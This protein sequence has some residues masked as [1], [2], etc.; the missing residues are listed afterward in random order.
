[1]NLP[2]VLAV[3]RGLIVDTFAQARSAGITI[4]LL[5]VTAVCAFFCFS[6]D[7]VGVTPQLPTAPWEAKELIPQSEV[8]RLKLSVEQTRGEGVDV[9]TGEIRLLF[10]AVHIPLQRAPEQSVR[11]VQVFLAGIIAD[12]IGVLLALVWTA[13][14][15]PGF[16]AAANAN[17]LF[18]K[19][20]SRWSLLAG[21][22]LAILLLV[23]AQATLFLIAT[24][25]ALGVRTGMWDLH[26][27]LALPILVVHFGAFFGIAVL[28]A[29]LC[30]STVA[31]ALGTFVAWSICCGVNIAR[32]EV[33]LGSQYG[34]AG[35]ALEAA[36]WVLPKPVDYSLILSESLGATDDTR[37]VIDVD[38]LHARGS[39]RPDFVL[40]SGLLFAIGIVG[41][42]GGALTRR[43]Y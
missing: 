23:V 24:W 30:R 9:P 2:A 39:F 40:G 11:L 8:D 26:Y 25:V 3:S 5:A 21:K 6:V 12:T 16:L 15:L 1:M 19:P 38:Q 27:F 36:Y 14:F 17:V 13:S 35:T 10:G 20:I 4:G 41:I 31:C 37:S 28:L 29:V 32:H 22:A 18:T 7:V 33:V 43:D 34:A 42:A